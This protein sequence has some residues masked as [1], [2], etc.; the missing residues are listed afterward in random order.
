MTNCYLAVLKKFKMQFPHAHFEIITR[1]AGSVLAPSW[2]LLTLSKEV[3]L[4][5]DEYRKLFTTEIKNN[6]IARK[7]I[8]EIRELV[9]DQLIFLVCY[10]K[11]ASKCH[12]SIVK[13]MIVNNKFFEND[14]FDITK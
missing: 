13:E 2:K 10:E 12:R 4:S 1:T 7:C 14:G 11:D 3:G 5:F 9:K 6:P 8:E